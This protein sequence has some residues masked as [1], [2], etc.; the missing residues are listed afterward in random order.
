[1][2]ERF[3]AP[4]PRGLEPVL[5]AELT[6]IGADDVNVAEGGVGFTGPL[7]LAYR[8]NLES[9]IASRILWRV[10]GGPYR[11][12]HALYALV[13]SIDWTRLFLPARTLRVDVAAT[14][15]PLQSLEFATLRVKDAIC[16]R[17]RADVNVRPS[18]DK[19]MPD[20][21]VHAYLTE[22]D[23]TIY[24]DTSGEPLFKRGYRRDAEEAPLRENIAAGV[25]A[26]TGW[27]PDTPF[28]DPM[29]G[30]GTIAIEAALIAADR[31]PG[32]SRTFGFQKLA[33]F[34]GPT[35]QRLKQTARDRIRP[36]PPSP[37]ITASDNAPGAIGRTQVNLRAAQLD[38]FVAVEEADLL[39]RAA[40]APHGVM[41][42]NPPYGV[43]L[44]DQAQM[45]Q[46]YPLLGDALKK[47]FAGWT[48]YFFTGD[49]RLPKL[50]HL[51]VARKTPLY[52]G[53][54]ECRLFEFPL[55]AGRHVPAG[56]E[57]PQ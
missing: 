44:S 1:M 32:L 29:C 27:S 14:R 37:L 23:A 39:T 43:R 51:K 36:A 12:E 24:V 5:A 28:L 10:G 30:S 2:T 34:D 33:W 22:R 15:S 3:F 35:W 47:H 45:A 46:F 50:I 11:D 56:S 55:V 18:I 13:Q 7:D 6:R 57:R 49:L 53:A 17:F 4:C 16:D 48:A 41:L 19:R 20:V 42:T 31:A 38:D 9:R 25:I 54:I 40:P 26:L 21:R 52:N 8:A